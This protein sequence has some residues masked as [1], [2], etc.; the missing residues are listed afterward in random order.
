MDVISS[1]VSSLQTIVFRFH[2]F[3]AAVLLFH[4]YERSPSL[5][6]FN[7]LDGEEF[8]HLPLVSELIKLLNTIVGQNSKF[9]FK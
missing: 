3:L 5:Q 7:V 8:I 9:R 2:M 1:T 6:E 4:E